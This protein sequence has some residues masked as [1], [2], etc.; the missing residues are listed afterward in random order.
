[1]QTDFP[2]AIH[3]K[4]LVHEVTSLVHQCAVD[5]FFCFAY[6]VVL[7]W[8]RDWIHKNGVCKNKAHN[9]TTLIEFTDM[10]YWIV[11]ASF[12]IILP[13]FIEKKKT[14]LSWE[15]LL[16]ICKD[17]SV[18]DIIYP[19]IITIG[20]CEYAQQFT[21]CILLSTYAYWP[22]TLTELTNRVHSPVFAY[23]LLVNM[24]RQDG[25]LHHQMT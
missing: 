20:S 8:W 5:I 17:I 24:S 22:I 21:L 4:L 14:L 10:Y 25:H 11:L 7:F 6:G 18:Q 13:K 1:M 15:H 23:H 3:Q 16:L 2:H 19:C 9:L 12:C